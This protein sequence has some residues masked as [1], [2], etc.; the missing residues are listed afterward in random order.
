MDGFGFRPG[1]PEQAFGGLHPLLTL[2]R[3]ECSQ[4]HQRIE[5][6]R[7]WG[8]DGDA[9]GVG[10]AQHIAQ[11]PLSLGRDLRRPDLTVM[12][13]QAGKQHRYGLQLQLVFGADRRQPCPGQPGV[14]G[15]QIEVE[16]QAARR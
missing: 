13:E 16:A 15:N 8:C 6:V 7:G 3:A 2:Q 12:L 10:L 1:G 5:G 9:V 11:H 14:V 4:G